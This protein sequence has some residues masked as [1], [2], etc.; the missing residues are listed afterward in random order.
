MKNGYLSQYFEGVIAKRL[1]GVEVD[2]LKSNQHEFNG[3]A[4]MKEL[5]GTERKK[6]TTRF[7]FLDDEN[8]PI[9]EDGHMTWYDARANNPN[10]SEY[11]L[12]FSACICGKG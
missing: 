8:P 9:S 6:L 2:S 11:R 12:F 1:S 3:V 5:F 7:L 4:S 10:R